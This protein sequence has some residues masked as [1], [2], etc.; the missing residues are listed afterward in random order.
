ML[1]NLTKYGKAFLDE[2]RALK[3]TGWAGFIAL[4][5]VLFISQSGRELLKAQAGVLAWKLVLVG[6]A[7]A[8]AHLVRRQLFPY[9]DVS[10]WLAEKSQAG[11]TVFLAICVIYAVIILAIC[12]GL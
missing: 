10:A 5:G 3:R 2:M 1:E 9:V 12:S 6:T 8:V 11:A 4:L 7:V